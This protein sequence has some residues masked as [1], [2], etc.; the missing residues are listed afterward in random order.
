MNEDFG[1]RSKNQS[2]MTDVYSIIPDIEYTKKNLRKWM[3][4]SNRKVSF[5]FNLL[6]GK[7]FVR[8]EPM[9][10][11][12]MISP[13]FSS[14]SY[15][16]SFMRNFCSGNQVMHKPSE[17]TPNSASLLKEICDKAFDENEFATVLGGP[18]VGSEFTTLN[19]D[20]LLFT[21][22]GNIGKL[23]MKGAAENLVPVTLE[24]GGKSPVIIGDNADLNMT[25]KKE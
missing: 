15:F 6:G 2:M 7:A 12:G 21:G 9:G 16:L 5:P 10:T 11:V 18:D 25:A 22:S 23:V 19:F 4:I 17:Y 8:Y 13:E 3:K 14:K 1:V 24:L 20:H